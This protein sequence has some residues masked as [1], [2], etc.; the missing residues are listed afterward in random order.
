MQQFSIWSLVSAS[1]VNLEIQILGP[2][3]R[4]NLKLSPNNVC[5]NKFSRCFW[6][7]SVNWVDSWHSPTTCLPGGFLGS[8]KSVISFIYLLSSLLNL[9]YYFLSSFPHLCR[10]TYTYTDRDVDGYMAIKIYTFRNPFIVVWEASG[11]STFRYRS[12][13]A[14][15]IRKSVCIHSSSFFTPNKNAIVNQ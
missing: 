1:L 8:I 15:F 13:F 5:F 14:I 2:Y 10:H 11:K 4:L 7:I 9:C 3:P 12:S 6:W